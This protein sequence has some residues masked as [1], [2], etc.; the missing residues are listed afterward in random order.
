V[1]V[2]DLGGRGR[3]SI[4]ACSSGCTAGHIV[5]I[6]H[7]TPGSQGRRTAPWIELDGP[8]PHRVPVSRAKIAEVKA[9]LG[10]ARPQSPHLTSARARSIPVTLRRPQ[11]GRLEGRR[12]GFSSWAAHPSR[13]AE[14]VIGPALRADPLA[15]ASGMTGPQS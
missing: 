1:P 7:V 3:S 4:P 2:V 10:L 12:P 5:A 13:L 15:R 9:R 11:R 14:P 6:P 8:S